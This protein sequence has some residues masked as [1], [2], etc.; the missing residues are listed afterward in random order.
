MPAQKVNVVERGI[1]KTFLMSRNPIPGI[2]RSNGHGRRQPGQEVVSRQSNLLVESSRAVTEAKLREMLIEALKNQGKPFGYYFADI[3]G[4]FTTT[5]RRGIQAFKVIPVVVYRV[6][7]DGRPDELVRGADLVGT[8]R[9]EITR[10]DLRGV[11][12]GNEVRFRSSHRYEGTTLHYEFAGQL[13]GDTIRG[14]VGLGEYGEAEW[15]ATRHRYPA[16]GRKGARG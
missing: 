12:E 11:V 9:G 3:T 16:P 5:D 14:R 2:E 13:S 6:F 7:A 10:G 15:V 4:G 8:H 1:L